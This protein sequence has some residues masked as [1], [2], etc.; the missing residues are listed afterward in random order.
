MQVT[1]N[2]L[3]LYYNNSQYHLLF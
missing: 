2:I 3:Q 1:N